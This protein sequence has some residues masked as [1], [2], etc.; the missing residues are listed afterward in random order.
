M[1][2]ASPLVTRLYQ[3][4]KPN[5]NLDGTR[6][7]RW[8]EDW[9]E[10]WERLCETVNGGMGRGWARA[11]ASRRS[12]VYT[13]NNNKQKIWETENS[14]PELK[15]FYVKQT[16]CSDRSMEVLLPALLGNHDDKEYTY[17]NIIL[18]PLKAFTRSQS[19]Y[20]LI[21]VV[22]GAV[23]IPNVSQM[24]SNVSS[25]CPQGVHNIFSDQKGQGL[26]LASGYFIKRGLHLRIHSIHDW[27]CNFPHK[28]LSLSVGWLVGRSVINS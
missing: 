10:D 24:L 12:R 6:T 11:I 2:K 25:W 21:I 15:H 4:I 8:G 23:I 26:Y 13:C 22:S 20:H 28:S 16:K 17:N 14:D 19:T 1:V 9:G 5:T 7:G 27:K 18:L 3:L